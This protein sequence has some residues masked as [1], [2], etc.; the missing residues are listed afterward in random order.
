MPSQNAPTKIDFKSIPAFAELKEEK[1][2]PELMQDF[3]QAL[4][5]IHPTK[6]N[7]WQTVQI[8]R[9]LRDY[10]QKIKAENDK[11]GKKADPKL[12][13]LL[14]QVL[15]RATLALY[16]PTDLQNIQQLA[17]WA[18]Q[19]PGARSYWSKALSIT[20]YSFAT[21]ALII[22]ITLLVMPTAGSHLLLMAATF[23]HLSSVATAMAHVATVVA[24]GVGYGVTPALV[25]G[26]AG[27]GTAVV[28]GGINYK[29]G[30]FKDQ[31]VSRQVGQLSRQL[32]K[33][34]QAGMPAA[35]LPEADLATEWR[36][37]KK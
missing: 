18:P 36:G 3:S 13:P 22:G 6:E 11:K 31:S 15:Y 9:L 27:V 8:G 35:D 33:D 1:L 5:H 21:L 16:Q 26:I 4:E 10:I 14:N 37:L 2:Y 34:R 23:T 20:L 29:I 28:G 19:V 12:V 30:L 7:E 17:L 32:P 24:N 25:G